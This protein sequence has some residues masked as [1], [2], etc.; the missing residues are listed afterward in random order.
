M[1]LLLAGAGYQDIVQVTEGVGCS[2]QVQAAVIAAW[3]PRTI[4]FH[5]H[6]QWCRP[7]TRRS[8][9]N[10]VSL[11]LHKIRFCRHQLGSIWAAKLRCGGRPHRLDVMHCLVLG[12]RQPALRVGHMLELAEELLKKPEASLPRW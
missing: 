6:V 10:P 5:N 3:P 12:R 11:Q 9:D 2:D 7:G 4:W 1:M 8:P